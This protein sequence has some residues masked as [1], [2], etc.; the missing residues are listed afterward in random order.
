MTKKYRFGKAI[1]IGVTDI[2]LAKGNQTNLL[3]MTKIDEAD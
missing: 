1:L 2:G 3:T